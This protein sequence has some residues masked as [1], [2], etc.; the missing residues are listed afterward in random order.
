MA[1]RDVTVFYALN[2]SVSMFKCP[3]RIGL[4]GNECCFS[5]AKQ[6]EVG[7]IVIIIIRAH[8]PLCSARMYRSRS[9]G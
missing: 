3:K 2:Q 9:G 6:K 8:H 7:T 5:A 1:N 4:L